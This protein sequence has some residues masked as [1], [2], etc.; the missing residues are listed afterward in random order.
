MAWLMVESG[1][2][3]PVPNTLFIGRHREI[4]EVS[5]LLTT[6]RLVTIIGPGG[7]GK[8][9]LAFEVLRRHARSDRDAMRM[10]DLSGVDDPALV[11]MVVAR[12]IGLPIAIA[13]SRAV[14]P[15]PSDP[16]G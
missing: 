13:S 5:K 11:Q 2:R 3:P 14:K 15:P 7:S 10:A 16:N 4:T 9:R 6:S 1:M 8:T 12:A